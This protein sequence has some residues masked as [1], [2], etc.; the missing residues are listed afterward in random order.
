MRVATTMHDFWPAHISAALQDPIEP[1]ITQTQ[2][3]T[4]EQIRRGLSIVAAAVHGQGMNINMVTVGGTVNTMLLRTRQSTTDVDIFFRTKARTVDTLRVLTAATS[5][6]C[7]GLGLEE[8]WLNDDV[9]LYVQ[10]DSLK[11][12]YEEA[13][14]QNEIVFRASGFTVYAAPWRFA[15][16]TKVD[17]L[18]KAEARPYDMSDAVAFLSRLVAQHGVALRREELASWAIEFELPPPSAWVLDAL[19]EAYFEANN[20]HGLSD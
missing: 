10:E 9:A 5:A 2:R 8:G 16:I 20:V 3:L 18:S 12:L 13:I 7:K 17:R 19:A 6:A 4:P 11:E 15:L 14:E 1:A